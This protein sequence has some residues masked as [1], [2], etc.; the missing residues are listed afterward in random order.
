[1]RTI[2]KITLLLIFLSMA[3]AQNPGITIGDKA[4]SFVLTLPKNA[5]Q[6][7]SMPYVGRIVL[8]HFYSTSVSKSTFYNKPFNKLA[9]RYKDAIF[10]GAEG[11]EAIEIAVQSDKTAWSEEI[12]HDTL[13][14]VINGIATRGYNDDIC[15]KYGINS[16]P[17]DILIDENGYVIAL[18]PKITIIE[19]ILDSKKNF[20]LVRKDIIG[21]LAYSS[22]SADYFKFA[23]MYLFNA[24]GDSIARTLTDENGKF[25][26]SDIKLNQDFILKVD[27]GAD[28]VLSD[29]MA[30]FNSKGERVMEAKTEGNGF[31]FYIPSNFSSKIVDHSDDMPMEGDGNI[32]QIDVNKHLSFKNNGAELTPNDEIELKSVIEML[33]KN[34]TISVEISG[35]ANTKLDP[36]QAQALT[37]KEIA[38]VKSYL[39]KKGIS[40]SRILTY[41]KGNSSPLV[42]CKSPQN[43]TEEQHA[44]NKRIEFRL[45]KD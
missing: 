2:L 13:T 11:F 6:G 43:C 17:T 37:L 41:S 14:D 5:T 26:F 45:Y 1:M 34:K 28:F 10:R 40:L 39:V 8:L 32:D 7:F 29:P 38:T 24:Y 33:N 12:A 22:T 36:K 16:L 19:D 27:N 21:T 9:K 44:K 30:L 3:R 23:K 4:Q 35:H 15:K 31:M 25:I 42:N 20:Q 18:N